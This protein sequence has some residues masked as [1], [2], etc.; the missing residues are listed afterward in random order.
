MAYEDDVP[1][2]MREKKAPSQSMERKIKSIISISG[3]YGVAI[4]LTY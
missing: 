1:R 2:A 3:S 4:E